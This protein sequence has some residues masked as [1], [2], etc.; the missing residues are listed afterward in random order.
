MDK[1]K[2]RFFT[3]REVFNTYGNNTVDKHQVNGKYFLVLDEKNKETY[4]EKEVG[5]MYIIEVDGGIVLDALAE[6]V[7]N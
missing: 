5:K 4:N 3:S 1:F 6:E 7:E 2:T